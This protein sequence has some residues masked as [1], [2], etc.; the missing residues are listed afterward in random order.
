MVR[1]IFLVLL[2][3]SSIYSQASAESFDI[4]IGEF[5]IDPLFQKER[6]KYPFY[7]TDCSI[8]TE[9]DTVTCKDTLICK[10]SSQ[11]VHLKYANGM[12][13]A[14]H[15]LFTD[16]KRKNKKIMP[17]SNFIVMDF[18]IEDTDCSLMFIFE[19]INNSWFLIKKK[20]YEID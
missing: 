2:I 6:V 5:F 12:Q 17:E 10:N 1:K 19:K 11:W 20:Q 7:T 13:R 4:F 14:R 16:E 8:S 9:N 18:E 15:K 3:S